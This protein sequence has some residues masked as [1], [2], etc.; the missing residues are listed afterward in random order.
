MA[1]ETGKMCGGQEF[2]ATE[3]PIS[4]SGVQFVLTT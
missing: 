2:G 4:N 1:L 3:E